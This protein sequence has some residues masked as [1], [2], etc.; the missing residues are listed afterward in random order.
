ME[1]LKKTSP[2]FTRIVANLRLVV[3]FAHE[4]E[5]FVYFYRGGGGGGRSVV[6]SYF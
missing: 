2:Y 3:N 4:K 5:I 6:R 1:I